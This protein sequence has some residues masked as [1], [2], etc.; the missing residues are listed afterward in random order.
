VAR[1]ERMIER[2]LNSEVEKLGGVT[3]KY[4]SPGRAGVAD[5]LC[6]FPR[7]I[8]ALVEVKIPRGKESETQKRERARMLELGH[9]AVVVFDKETVDEFLQNVF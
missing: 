9:T 7:G 4:T 2:Y 6:F 1:H 5:R 8:F 3:R